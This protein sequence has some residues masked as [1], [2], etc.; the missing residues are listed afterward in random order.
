[1]GFLFFSETRSTTWNGRLRSTFPLVAVVALAAC[2]E[3]AGSASLAAADAFCVEALEGVDRF[4]A[5][6]RT[7]QASGSSETDRATVVVAG[8]AELSSGMNAFAASDYSSVQ[9]QQFVNLMPLIAYDEALQPVPNLAESWEVG[10][11]GT[12]ITFHLRS[13]VFWHD[14][15]PTAAHDVA[16]TYIRM[17]DPRTAFQ[18]AGYWTFYE[19]GSE[20][21]EVLDDFTVR[22]HMRPHA[23]FMDPWRTVGIMPEHLLGDVAPEDLGAHPF[24]NQCPVGNGPFVFVEHRA[25]DRWVF[26]ANPVFPSELG[27]QPQVDRLIY[28]VIPEQAT[29]LAELLTEGI[30]V[31][32]APTP[33]QAPSILDNPTVDLRVFFSRVYN[34]VAWNSRRPQLQDR[35]VRKALTLATNRRE[36][37]RGL[38]GEYGQLANSGVPPF[39]WAYDP[40][41]V[42]TRY[43]PDE[44]RALLEQA[45]WRDGDGD[46]VRENAEGVR[47]SITL[48]YSP[49]QLR[50]G[51]AEIM[52]AQLADV[53]VEVVPRV[54]EWATLLD[55]I[56]DPAVRDFDGVVLAWGTDFRIDESD[57]FHSARI[58]DGPVAL[59]GLSNPE[60]DRYLDTLPLVAG[61]DEARQ[62]WHEYQKVL[63]VEHPYTYLY[64]PRRLVGVNRR[65]SNVTMDVRGEWVNVR[66]WR[67]DG[68]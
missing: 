50:Q 48:K 18:N 15:E 27:G 6:A 64:F 43:D 57:L 56:F 66:E 14:G 5:Q 4:M 40:D 67:V 11:D 13:D 10:E 44:A 39:H 59:A 20:G 28:R 55:Q 58:D 34:F 47:L 31:Y 33:D 29:L 36:M 25:G 7:L 19:S 17:T 53:G 22:M 45:G 32:V 62:L 26:E 8:V 12:T 21:V 49:G 60:L 1:M 37:V 68:S 41:V 46:G 65:L 61:R 30:D 23:D 51:V 3:G 54:V 52:Q 35:R 24:G 16:F 42:D 2:G 38:L 63:A 9:V